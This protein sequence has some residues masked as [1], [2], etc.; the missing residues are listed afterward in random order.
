MRSIGAF[1]S[2][3]ILFHA[4]RANSNAIAL[5]VNVARLKR[6][7]QICPVQESKSHAAHSFPTAQKKS[8]SNLMAIIKK[9]EREG[10]RVFHQ[11]HCDGYTTK[12]SPPSKDLHAYDT[13]TLPKNPRG[14]WT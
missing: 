14:R 3:E 11:R 13:H 1:F 9:R 4:H 2:R 10:K 6:G 12:T 7:S 5:C 8:P